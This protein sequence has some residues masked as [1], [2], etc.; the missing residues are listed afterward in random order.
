ML[1]YLTGQSVTGNGNII[2]GSQAAQTLTTGT[3]NILIGT[4]SQAELTGTSNACVI[5]GTTSAI[6]QYYFGLGR[7]NSSATAFTFNGTGGSGSNNAGANV[8]LAGGFGTGTAANGYAGLKYGLLTTTGSTAHTAS[9]LTNYLGGFIYVTTADLTLTA[10]TATTGTL[11]GAQT[12]ARPQGTLT[13][14]ANL[15]DVA[16][17]IRIC[18]KGRITTS[19]GGPTLKIDAKLGTTVIATTGA[20]APL[21][22]ATNAQFCCEVV[23]VCRST[24]ATGTVQ[25]DGYVTQ[26]NATTFTPQTYDMYQAV[27]TVDTTASQAID[28]FGTWSA[29]TA[30][31]AITITNLTVEYR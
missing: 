21:S 3:N 31:N 6:T 12:N 17:T 9:T 24:G 23:L 18:A 10:S 11:I 15:L 28:L 7:T 5:G 25:G 8:Q 1:G 13:L 26:S 19:I 4:G 16:S 22:G 20:A 30:G 29:N 2:I 14:D 27:T